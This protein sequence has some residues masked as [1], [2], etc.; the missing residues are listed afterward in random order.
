MNLDNYIE[1]KM[2]EFGLTITSVSE[3]SELYSNVSNARLRVIFSHLH[4]EYIRLFRTMNERLPTEDYTAHFWADPSRDLITIVEA[5]FEMFN[6]LKTTELSF[7]IEKEYF[8]IISKCRDFLCKSGGSA[9]PEH[10]PKIQLYYTIPIFSPSGSVVIDSPEKKLN[11]MLKLIGEG[12]YA[13]VFKFKDT[14]YNKTYALKRAKKDLDD[15]ELERFKREFEQM[16]SM[17]SPY[18]VEVYS[19]NEETNEYI[20]EFLDCTLEKYIKDNNSTI[21]L[22]ERRGIILQLIRGY[23]YLHSKS[24]FHRDVSFKNVLVKRHEN[25]NVFKISDFGLVKIPDSDLTSENSE[26][27]GCLN[28]PTLKTKGFGKYELLDEIYALTLLFV[29]ILTGKTNFGNIKDSN[30]RSF[31]DNGTNADRTKRFQNLNELKAGVL[32]CVSSMK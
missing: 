7:Q 14:F 1:S 6:T 27:K 22:D 21:T 17:S 24:L 32:K 3:Y 26:L 11:A 2:R 20:M 4:A 18:I 30:I 16:Q 28:D 23:Q 13:Q 10:T 25:V 15:K 8:E 9:I 5:T 12:S 29:Y 19:F 31:M